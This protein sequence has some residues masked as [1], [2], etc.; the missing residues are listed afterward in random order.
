MATET[1]VR[2]SGKCHTKKKTFPFFVLRAQTDTDTLVAL[3]I[4]YIF[5]AYIFTIVEHS[6]DL[7]KCKYVMFFALLTKLTV[8]AT[9][10]FRY[11]H[12]DMQIILF[13]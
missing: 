13:L 3:H 5:I 8:I 9:C 2:Y 6:L 4:Q 10:L 1:M 7:Q 11:I 12:F